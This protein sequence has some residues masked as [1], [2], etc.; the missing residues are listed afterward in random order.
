MHLYVYT[1]Y[2]PKVQIDKKC[3]R[4]FYCNAYTK[5]YYQQVQLT[6]YSVQ[7]CPIFCIRNFNICPTI[8]EIPVSQRESTLFLLLS[9]VFKRRVTK[10]SRS[11][12]ID[13]M[14]CDVARISFFFQGTQ[15]QSYA[16]F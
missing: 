11:D 5:V 10:L 16:I 3:D 6:K 9:V 8:G 12:L 1:T 14:L 2:L 4:A 15:V 13:T 7:V